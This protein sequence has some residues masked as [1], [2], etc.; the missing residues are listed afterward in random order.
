[1]AER[2]LIEQL[3]QALE[4]TLSDSP[5]AEMVRIAGDLRGMPTEEFRTKL[6]SDLIA[7]ARSGMKE[8]TMTAVNPIR[9]GFHTL[10]PYL[11]VN[12]ASRLIQF[13]TDAFG[14]VERL[15]VAMPDG[16]IM[17]ADMQVGDSMIELSDANEQYPARP[18]SNHLYVPDMDAVYRRAMEAGATSLC[19]PTDQFYGD[20]EAG[21]EDPV[22]N[23]WWIATH[24]TPHGTDWPAHA[25]EGVRTVT[26]YL[27][28]RGVP[29]LID[30]L[31]RAFNVVEEARYASPEGRIVHAKLR[32]G[33]SILEMGEAHGKYQPRPVALHLYVEDTDA[34]YRRALEA[35]A[36][37]LE[38][39]EDKPYGD[40]AAGV[41]D[42]SGNSWF[43][44]THIRDVKF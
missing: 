34:L 7:A 32:V 24:K 4:A 6:K 37:S 30:F 35:G 26:P 1:M 38:A 23:Y 18:A 14:A 9:E 44:A 39:P 17:H 19:E 3:N 20:R 12:G 36:Q 33:D 10:T 8:Q 27:L 13:L 41:L 22:G 31:K 16:K 21:I 25:P 2:D 28:A 42:P 43:I 5:L 11:M 29:E 40:R 15:K